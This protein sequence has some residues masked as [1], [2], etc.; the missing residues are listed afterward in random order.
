MKLNQLTAAAMSRYE[1][2]KERS[3]TGLAHAVE[4]R[5]KLVLDIRIQPATIF[6]SEGGSYKPDAPTII[7]DLGLLTISTIDTP[8]AVC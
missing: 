2:V 7:A 5:T 3:V 1:E 8:A 6:I 4:G